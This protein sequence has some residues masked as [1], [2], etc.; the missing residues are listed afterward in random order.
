MN[1]TEYIALMPSVP[2]YRDAAFQVELFRRDDTGE[3]TLPSEVVNAR[4]LDELPTA[5]RFLAATELLSMFGVYIDG[6]Q[7]AIDAYDNAELA[8]N[9]THDKLTGQ[10]NLRGL[11]EW[12]DKHYKPEDNSY[13]VLFL[14]VSNFKA[15]N[16]VLNHKAGDKTLCYIFDYLSSN[17]RLG[18]ALQPE[19]LTIERRE[20]KTKDLMCIA[21]V[22]GDEIVCILN[23][24]GMTEEKARDAL[25]KIHERLTKTIKYATSEEIPGKRVEYGFS[26]GYVLIN[27]DNPLS[28]QDAK[29]AANSKEREYKRGRN[30][31][32]MCADC[33]HNR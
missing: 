5:Y 12:A 24:N 9:A 23:F 6:V 19:G 22:G 16:D 18:Q 30:T 10:L 20:H 11:Y 2:D 32:K 33:P 7:H 27:K 21:R 14:D 28:I 1:R 4:S 15:V 29:D 17:I 8:Y 3:V 25:L 31:K 26:V 13:G